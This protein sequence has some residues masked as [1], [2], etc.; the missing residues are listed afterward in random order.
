MDKYFENPFALAC[1]SD[2][3]ILFSDDEAFSDAEFKSFNFD[4]DFA[5]ELP[6]K[7]CSTCEWCFD[8]RAEP[9]CACEFYGE[10]ISAIQNKIMSP[11]PGWSISYPA[12]CFL[13]SC[14][15]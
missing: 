14:D 6:K 1:A 15:K 8:D 11:C 12:Y 2:E 3:N 10:K 4:I 7:S 9:I 13:N 5:S